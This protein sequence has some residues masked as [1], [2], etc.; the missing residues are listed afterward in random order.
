MNENQTNVQANNEGMQMDQRNQSV[1]QN[2]GNQESLQKTVVN[3]KEVPLHEVQMMEEQFNKQNNQTGIQQHHDNSSESVQAGQVAQNQVSQQ[4]DQRIKRANVQSGQSHL[5]PNFSQGQQTQ[6]SQVQMQ[7]QEN[8]Q[9]IQNSVDAKA[10]AQ[11]KTKK[12]N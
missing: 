4:Q 5:S 11:A 6:Q 12:D 9:T 7:A 1:Q 10:K 8:Q 2:Q 3:G